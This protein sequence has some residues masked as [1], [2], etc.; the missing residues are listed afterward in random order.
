MSGTGWDIALCRARVRELEAE[1][2][3]LGSLSEQRADQVLALETEVAQQQREL[4]ALRDERDA[5]N[6]TARRLREEIA[7]LVERVLREGERP[8]R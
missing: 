6:Q 8:D 2:R 1:V 7:V 4:A 5:A 3:R